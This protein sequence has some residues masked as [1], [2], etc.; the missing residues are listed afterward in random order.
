MV[1]L[2]SVYKIEKSWYSDILKTMTPKF[3]TRGEAADV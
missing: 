3:L 1:S 2:V